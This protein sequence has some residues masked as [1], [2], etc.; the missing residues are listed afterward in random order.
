MID[1]GIRQKNTC[2]WSVAWRITARL[3]PGHTFD[4]PVQ[5]GRRVDQKPAVKTFGVPT[6][7]D[8]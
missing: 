1:V 8:T 6:D 3:Q 7:G 4:L 2:N 5:I